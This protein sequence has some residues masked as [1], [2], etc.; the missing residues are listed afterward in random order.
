MLEWEPS[1]TNLEKMEE[2]LNS[3]VKESNFPSV[4]KDR[5][6]DRDYN[7]TAP[8]CQSVREILTGH[9]MQSLMFSISA[10]SRAL[11]NSDY[12]NPQDRENL[13]KAIFEGWRQISQ[14]LFV[15]LPPLVERGHASFDGA[16]FVLTADFGQN[17]VERFHRIM[18]AI[19]FNVARWYQDQIFSPK[20]TPLIYRFLS[21][22]PSA[23][24]KHELMLLIIAKRPEGWKEVL[25]KYIYDLPRKSFYLR[26]IYGKLTTEYK[27]A[28]VDSKALRDL[29]FSIKM[30]A[31]KHVHGVKAVGKV[32]DSVLPNREESSE[33][34][35]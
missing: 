12:V 21:E 17:P 32:L 29:E 22:Q 1:G 11:R 7:R 6:A 25:K 9:S 3:G 34:F 27:Y 2:E 26:D 18:G 23:L 5:Y 19:P 14:V 15:L 10:A 13:L 4:I 31:T 35:D 16:G 24:I 8:Y 28:F 30:I 33:E 20:M